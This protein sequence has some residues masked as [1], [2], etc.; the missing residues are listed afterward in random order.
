MTIGEDGF[1]QIGT[2]GQ[3]VWFASKVNVGDGALNARLTAPIDMDGVKWQPIGTIA[4]NYSGTFDGQL[5][6]ITNLNGMLFGTTNAATLTGIAIESGN[7]STNAGAA[8]HTGSIVGHALNKTS[9]SNSYSKAFIQGGEGDLG[10]VAGKFVGPITNVLFAGTFGAGI[11][12]W[13]SADWQARRT[14]AT[15]R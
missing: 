3:L 11:T 12:T 13:S 8:A 4:V 1:Y 9:L 5:Y 2:A 6:P 14:M 7:V 10:G 15:P